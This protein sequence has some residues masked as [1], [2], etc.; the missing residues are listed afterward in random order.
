MPAGFLH[1]GFLPGGLST[2]LT[3][4]GLERMKGGARDVWAK[5]TH[6]QN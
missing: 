2:I 1:F 3:L 4:H 5:G 6:G